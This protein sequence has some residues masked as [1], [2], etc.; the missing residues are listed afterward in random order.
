V[1]SRLSRARG[2]RRRRDG[3]RVARG[4]GRRTRLRRRGFRVSGGGGVAWVSGT[5]RRVHAGRARSVRRVG[6]R[7]SSREPLGAARGA[8]HG[9]ERTDGQRRDIRERRVGGGGAAGE[10]CRAKRRREDD[11]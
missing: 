6:R 1:R 7:L 11:L 8:S 4:I 2:G 9:E 10:R 5:V 3:G